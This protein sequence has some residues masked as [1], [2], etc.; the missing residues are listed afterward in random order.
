VELAKF[1]PDDEAK[2]CERASRLLKK[3]HDLRTIDKVKEELK[4]PWFEEVLQIN[5]R[6]SEDSSLRLKRLQDN[7]ETKE[8]LS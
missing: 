1:L 4:S 2:S 3:Q 7:F 8:H 6:I 5:K